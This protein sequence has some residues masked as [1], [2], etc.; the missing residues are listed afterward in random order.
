MGFKRPE[1]QIFSLR[2]RKKGNEHSLPFLRGLS[3]VDVNQIFPMKTINRLKKI[4]KNKSIIEERENLVHVCNS[5]ANLAEGVPLAG[6][7]NISH[8]DQNKALQYF[9]LSLKCEVS[10]SGSDAIAD[11]LTEQNG[12]FDICGQIDRTKRRYFRALCRT[13]LRPYSKYEQSRLRQK[14]SK[15]ATFWLPASIA[16]RF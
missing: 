15:I 10:Y 3:S 8:S 4:T 9:S 2:P 16:A 7:G 11:E 12:G 5:V 14:L 13:R 6:N 1:V